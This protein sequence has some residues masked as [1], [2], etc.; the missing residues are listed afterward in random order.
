M[1]KLDYDYCHAAPVLEWM[2]QKWALVAMMRIEEAGGDETDKGIRFG[3]LFRTIPHISEKV[4]ASTLDYL[5]GEGLVVRTSHDSVPPCVEYSLTPLAR[6]FLREISCSTAQG[7][8][9]DRPLPR[10]EF[11]SRLADE[12]H[13]K[14]MG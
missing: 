7:F 11:E 6:N 14:N 13:Y 4:L 5:E 3:D 9:F 10:D 2:S 1:K 12:E 8:L